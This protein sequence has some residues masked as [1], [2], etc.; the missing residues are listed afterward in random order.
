MSVHGS[1]PR[2]P[3]THQSSGLVGGGPVCSDRF[4]AK[5]L[6]SAAVNLLIESSGLRLQMRRLVQ[7]PYDKFC[8]WLM[9]G[10]P[11][12]REQVQITSCYLHRSRSMQAV[13][14][15]TLPS[16]RTAASQHTADFARALC[17]KRRLLSAALRL[18]TGSV[19]QHRLSRPAK[20][21]NPSRP[22]EQG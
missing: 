8:L 7:R 4:F 6:E 3:L 2:T 9:R 13:A 1:F 11:R 20:V 10:I 17:R 18:S 21:F 19:T 5:L 16:V 15:L 12:R 22:M 14:P